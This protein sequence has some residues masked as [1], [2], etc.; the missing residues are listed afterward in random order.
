MA[1]QLSH[2]GIFDNLEGHTCLLDHLSQVINDPSACIK[3]QDNGR[4][5]RESLLMGPTGG[6]KMQSIWEGNRLITAELFG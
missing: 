1:K 2:I 5:I 4:V 6:L 3:F